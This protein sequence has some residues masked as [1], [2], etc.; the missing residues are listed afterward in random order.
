MAHCLVRGA[1]ART[2]GD[3]FRR[4]TWSQSAK[5]NTRHLPQTHCLARGAKAR[6][7]EATPGA[8]LGA[9]RHSWND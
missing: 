5:A 7:A 2:T 9:A 3:L 8:L 4:T 1:K 6:T